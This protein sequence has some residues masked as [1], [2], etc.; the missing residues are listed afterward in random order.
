MSN[1]YYESNRQRKAK[2]TPEQQEQV[3]EM[4]R[5]QGLND[6]AGGMDPNDPTAT[7]DGV[8][9]RDRYVRVGG[10]E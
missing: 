8:Y 10:R 7:F 3:D 1:D 5:Q 6:Y 9:S 4:L 2:L